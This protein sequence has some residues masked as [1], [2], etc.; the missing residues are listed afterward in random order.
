VGASRRRALPSR[1][2]TLF[3][4]P[5]TAFLALTRPLGT[6]VTIFPY[7]P[8]DDWPSGRNLW[9]ALLGAGL[10]LGVAG[11]TDLR[12]RRLR[13]PTGVGDRR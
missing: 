2:I 5:A 9:L 10:C 12:W 6:A 11:M 3:S 13:V 4:V 7:G 1:W 8:A